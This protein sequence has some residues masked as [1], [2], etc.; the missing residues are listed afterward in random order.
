[1]DGLVEEGSYLCHSFCKSVEAGF[2]LLM[3]CFGSGCFD[4]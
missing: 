3:A 4:A 2:Q 1:M